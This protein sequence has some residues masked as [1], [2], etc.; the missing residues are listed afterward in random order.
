[1]V[2]S[3]D[4][5]Y[6]THADQVSLANSYPDNPLLQHRGQP[7]TH[8]VRLAK[9]IF[10]SL[11]QNAPTDIPFYDKAAYDGQGDRA[12]RNKWQKVNLP[13][14]SIVKVVLFEGWAVGFCPLSERDLKHKWEHAVKALQEGRYVGRLAHNTLE[15]VAAINHALQEYNHI[16]E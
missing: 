16:T 7:S 3:L 6:L 10:D 11:R 1:M 9:S 13:G 2:F 12:P 15:N 14:Q 5:L 8:D 4:D